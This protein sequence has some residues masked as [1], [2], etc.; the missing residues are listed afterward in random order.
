M[1]VKQIT[2]MTEVD[3]DSWNR[4]VQGK[5]PFVSHEFLAALEESGSVCAETGWRPRH[6]LV[7]REQEL[8]AAMPLYLKDHSWGEYVFDQQWADAYYQ[9]GMDYY[10]KWVNAVPFTPCQGQRLLLAPA[11]DKHS[12]I[13]RCI[14]YIKRLSEHKKISSLHCLFP[15]PVQ[16]QD[17]EKIMLLREGVQFHWFNRGYHDFAD[18]L[19][20]FSARQRKKISKERRKIAEQGI[21]L[22]RLRGAEIGER[23]WRH[24]FRFYQATYLKRGQYPYLN[25]EFFMRLA[26]SMPDQLLL[27]LAV[28]GNKI[29]AAALSL[30]GEDTLYGR[31]WGSHNE[32]DGLH[33]ETCYYQG[34]EY[35]LEHGV[36]RFDSGAQGEHKISRGFEPVTT[37]SAHWL[38]NSRFS[39]LIAEFLRREKPLIRQYKYNCRGRLPFKAR[40]DN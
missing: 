9:S 25:Q 16:A 6:L 7:Y 38:Q 18:Y 20:S 34:L 33:F 31:Y 5:D 23:Q 35:C 39:D 15:D 24:F 10:P 37:Y 22:I 29:V 11:L 27:V 28:K 36:K 40:S 13:E 8:I 1:I 21:D 26:Q 30:I 4:L 32:Y 12:V 14:D 17:L 19:Q 2:S 3:A